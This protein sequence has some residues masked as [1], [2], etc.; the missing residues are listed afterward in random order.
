MTKSHPLHRKKAIHMIFRRSYRVRR[1][2]YKVSAI[3]D[4]VS[5]TRKGGVK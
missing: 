5:H 1:L 3:L 4:R 2:F